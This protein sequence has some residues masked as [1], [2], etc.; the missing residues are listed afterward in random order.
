MRLKE[1]AS[2]EEPDTTI[3]VPPTHGVQIDPFGNA[4]ISSG[5]I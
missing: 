3:V 4:L 5:G 1:P 2:F